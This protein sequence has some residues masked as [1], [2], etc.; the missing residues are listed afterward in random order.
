MTW[1][2]FPSPAP[3]SIGA[4]RSLCN[5][6]TASARTVSASPSAN[7]Q[8]SPAVS[9]DQPGRKGLG[10]AA[11]VAVLT[12]ATFLLT[13]L[14]TGLYALSF[15][16]RQYVEL[17]GQ[18]QYRLLRALADSLDAR[19]SVQ[20]SV[21]GAAA[22]QVPAPALSDAEQARRFLDSRTFLRR[23]FD[24]GLRLV[25]APEPRLL[26]SDETAARLATDFSEAELALFRRVADSKQTEISASFIGANGEPML[27]MATPLRGPDGRTVALL[28]GRLSVLASEI[29]GELREHRIG[30]TGYLYMSDP[31][32]LMLM[33]P[34]RERIARIAA[35]PGRNIA[36]DRAIDQG[37]EGTMATVNSTGQ[38]M[39]ASFARVPSAGW[40][41]A[42]N[43]PMTEVEAPY[44][45]SVKVVASVS[46]LAVASLLL[47]SLL[48]LRHMLA[49]VR[50]L[51]MHLKQVGTDATR[52]FSGTA[53]AELADIAGAYND[54]IARLARSEQLRDEQAAAVQ[55]LN[56][57]LEERVQRRTQELSDANTRLQSSLQRIQGM[58]HELLAAE[59]QASLGR[60]LASISHEL[61]TPIGNAL[62]TAEGLRAAGKELEKSLSAG[63]LSRRQLQEHLS[64]GDEASTLIERNLERAATLLESYRS[65]TEMPLQSSDGA[66]ALRPIVD[67]L[68]TTQQPRIARSGSRVSVDVS[69][70]LSVAADARAVG[71]ILDALLSNALL[72]GRGS[73]GADISINA[74]ADGSGRLTIIVS[75]K[76]PGIPADQLKHVFEPM[77][78]TKLAQGHSGLGLAMVQKLVT[79][80]LGGEIELSSTPGEGT[81]VR[82]LLP[83]G[84]G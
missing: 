56:D 32:R 25:Q 70:A 7:A 43:Y 26:G 16:E 4:P 65:L 66:T 8:S 50:Q 76:G 79:E 41:L 74:S 55:A 54:M 82:L 37:F 48:V 69:D 58:Q 83:A 72:H 44:Y 19:L 30:E 75:D 6:P 5:D 24:Q 22:G 62:C 42:A 51:S 21:L 81:R 59:K 64:F 57:E 18:H 52:P 15:F 40:V 60:M 20:R 77:Y 29:A 13:F 73:S 23:R 47:I 46:A 68:L 1:V 12:A 61:N 36:Y 63:T 49:P 11:R 38:R 17:T 27:S 9:S 14:G 3:R 33:H 35:Q 45:R 53:Q 71:L 78:T 39:L 28:T 10:M 2:R 34:D 31:Q 84:Q 67:A 80:L